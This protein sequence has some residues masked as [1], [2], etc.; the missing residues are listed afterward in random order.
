MNRR[1]NKTIRETLVERFGEPI[2]EQT[3]DDHVT[4]QCGGEHLK[5]LPDGFV[6]CEDC[7]RFWMPLDETWDKL[8]LA[9]VDDEKDVNGEEKERCE[10]C[11]LPHPKHM[12]YCSMKPDRYD[13]D[14]KKSIVRETRDSV[15]TSEVQQ[16]WE[17]L[18]ADHGRVPF[19]E[20]VSWLG[21][22]EDAVLDAMPRFLI[23][24]PE[25]DV[26]ERFDS[27]YPKQ[28]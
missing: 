4:C 1:K 2:N 13:L 27:G 6:R 17:D 15:S 21:A 28:I 11:G 25:G 7:G 18:Y 3:E 26:I 12:N 23:V 22:T 20:L 10:D 9:H 16:T 14:E 5:K 19:E 8:G 24:T